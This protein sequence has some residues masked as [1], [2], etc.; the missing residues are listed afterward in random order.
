MMG[1]V[2]LVDNT[3]T[4]R[5]RAHGNPAGQAEL[6]NMVAAAKLLVKAHDVLQKRASSGKK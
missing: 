5:W 2:L 3:G 4:V 1:H 6:D